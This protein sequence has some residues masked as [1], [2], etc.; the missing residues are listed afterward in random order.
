MK[1]TIIGLL[2]FAGTTH[3]SISYAEDELKAGLN[4][5]IV[6]QTC[7]ACHSLKLVT[8]NRAD[9]EGWLAMIRWMQEKQGLWPLG[10]NEDKILDYLSAYY[11]PTKSFRRTPLSSALMPPEE[12]SAAPTHK[13]PSAAPTHEEPSAA[14]THEEPSAALLHEES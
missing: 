6:S 13:E 2:L 4:V 9:R 11:G 7:I 5:E 10:D 14:P 8:Q 1:N 12:P 3:L